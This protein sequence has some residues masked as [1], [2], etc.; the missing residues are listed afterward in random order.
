MSDIITAREAAELANYREQLGQAA[1]KAAAQNTFS[2]YQG[3]KAANTT[4][5][6]AADLVLFATFLESVGDAP[7]NL[8]EDPQAWRGITWGLVKAFVAWMLKQGYATSTVNMR[9][10][11][12]KVYAE[13]AAKANTLEQNEAAMIRTI[14][15][16][17]RAEAKHK[18]EQ[19]EEA[20]I[21][22]RTGRKKA[23]AVS[24]SPNQAKAL[25]AQPDTPQGRR[26]ALLMCLLLDHG[27]RCG[28]VAGLTVDN[29]NLESGEMI[30]NRPKVDKVQTHRLTPATRRAAKAWFD[31]GDAPAIGRLLR[32][33]R[34]GGK[35]TSGGMC[36]QSITERVRVL[37]AA[38]GL[39]GLSAHD[40]RHYWATNAVRNGTPL[41]RLQDAG[42]WASMA[43]P[44]RYVE[45]AKIANEGV[46]LGSD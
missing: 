25:K 15:G 23:Q 1:N 3:G 24:I 40:C 12:V 11:T 22:T 6:H 18:D 37:G 9:L 10:S 34:K 28:E 42:G 30:F 43:M 4:R 13:L 39:E 46:H 5:R 32:G 26:D 36:E 44:L 19:R 8:I 17:R 16:Y 35:L 31:S 45:A 21:P 14:K 41:D 2:D 20:G 29:F 38:V 27:L 33:S 7:G